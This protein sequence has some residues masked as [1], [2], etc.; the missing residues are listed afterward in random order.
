[1]SG[2]YFKNMKEKHD[3]R[4]EEVVNILPKNGFTNI[5]ADLPNFPKKIDQK[6]WFENAPDKKKTP[7]ILAEKEGKTYI[8]EVKSEIEAFQ[9]EEVIEQLHVFHAYASQ[10]SDQYIFW[11]VVPKTVEEQVKDI[12]KKNRWESCKIRTI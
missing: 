11:L 1:M 8:I 9:Y 7:D 5:R 2:K 12:V 3:K 10:K 4:V 6:F